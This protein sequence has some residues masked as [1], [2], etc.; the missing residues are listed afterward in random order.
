MLSENRAALHEGS[1]TFSSPLFEDVL[2]TLQC[3]R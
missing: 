1:L 2:G 3:L